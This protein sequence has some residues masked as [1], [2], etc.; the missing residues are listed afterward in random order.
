MPRPRPRWGVDRGGLRGPTGAARCRRCGG[1]RTSPRRTGRPTSRTRRSCAPTTAPTGRSCASSHTINRNPDPNWFGHLALAGLMTA[2][3]PPV[4]EKLLLSGYLLLLPLY[5]PTPCAGAAR[6]RPA[7]LLIFPFLHNLFYHMGF[8][9]FCYSLPVFFLRLGY[10]LRHRE[11]FTP[12]RAAVLAVLGLLLFFCHLFSLAAPGVAA[13]GPRRLLASCSTCGP[14][15]RS[16]RA[17]ARG[18]CCPSTPS[19]PRLPSAAWSWPAGRVT[20]S[21]RRTGQPR[22]LAAEAGSP[23][24]LRQRRGVARAGAG[25]LLPRLHLPPSWWPAAGTAPRRG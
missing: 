21:S 19:S 1:S 7:V 5:W 4:A 9:N 8:Y 6:R 17:S 11:Q 20:P 14:A 15:C 2:F 3:P 18:R 24:L 10:W 23:R 25:P 12:A 13:G 22:D 16:G